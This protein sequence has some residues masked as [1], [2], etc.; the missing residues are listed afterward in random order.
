MTVCC[1]P[2]RSAFH[3]KLAPDGVSSGDPPRPKGSGGIVSTYFFFGGTN[4][5]DVSR[6]SVFGFSARGFAVGFP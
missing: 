6:G 5:L 3:P 2:R 4:R 1:G